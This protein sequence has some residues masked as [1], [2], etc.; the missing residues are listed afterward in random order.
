[1]E[2]TRSTRDRRGTSKKT[3]YGNSYTRIG[4]T[5]RVDVL[6]ESLSSDYLANSCE[7]DFFIVINILCK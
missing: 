7:F 6:E 3:M 5:M 2:V 1:M 4:H